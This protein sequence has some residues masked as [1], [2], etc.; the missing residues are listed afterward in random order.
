MSAWKF[1]LL[2]GASSLLVSCD[3]IQEALETCEE[4]CTKL[5]ECPDADPPDLTFGNFSTDSGFNA[6]DCATNC[7]AQ[8]TDRVFYGY[9][10]CQI[11]CITNEEC[12]SV[13]KCWQSG[14]DVYANYC[15][16]DREV[17]DIEPA[18]EDPVPDNGTETGN[19]DA[20][21][22]VEDPAIAIAIDDAENN[23]AYDF[24]MN[25]GDSPPDITG[26]YSVEGIIDYSENARA[27]GTQIATTICFSGQ[28]SFV[29]TGD[30]VTYCEH[31]VD[32]G[33]PS[34]PVTGTSYEDGT[35]DFSVF[36]TYEDIATIMFS[37][38]TDANG[39]VLPGVSAMVVYLH[40]VDIFEHSQTSWTRL[41]TCTGC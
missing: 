32:L 12:G 16:A 25:W 13:N 38:D 15:L 22:L 11:E 17:P 24:G 8:G 30:E 6:L 4:A 7:G 26:E 41:G 3:A 2:I 1:T 9:A 10:D 34:A 31:G 18:P 28:Q 21:E 36:L 23:N 39:E 40:G 29:D 5:D 37:G 14:S 19:S 35:G 20:D 27:Q 33:S